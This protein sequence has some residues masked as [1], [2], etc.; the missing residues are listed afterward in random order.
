MTLV[1]KLVRAASPSGREREAA[2]LLVSE[3]VDRGFEAQLD[4]VGNAVGVIGRGSRQI[5]L[6]G[7][8]DTVSGQI[9]VR[10]ENEALYGRGSVDAKGALA[11]FVEAAA[12][13]ENSSALKITVIGCVG[14][15]ANS[16]GARY[17]LANYKIPDYVIIGEPS[18]WEAI[19][20]G[21]RKSVV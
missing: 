14:E 12:A 2:R 1:E 13:F 9:P 20:L 3:L 15:E 21:D 6:V 5:Y 4:P 19:T 10:L 17:L 7:H 18:G 16:P 11:A 8:L